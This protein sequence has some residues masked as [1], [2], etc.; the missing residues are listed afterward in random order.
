MTE[1]EQAM[2]GSHL[3]TLIAA[4]CASTGP[5]LELGMGNFSTPALHA[6]CVTLGTGHRL[7]SIEKEAAWAEKFTQYLCD[8][9]KIYCVDYRHYLENSDP[10]TKWGVAFIDSSPGG[11]DRAELFRLLVNRSGYVVVHDYH[12]ENEEYI[13][14]LLTGLR[15]VKVVKTYQPPTL[16]VSKNWDFPEGIDR[17]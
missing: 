12:L 7:V 10:Y 8:S 5:V 11:A 15:S 16:I 1:Q 14:P 4:V 2:W 17:L 6:L 3:P 13:A 9:H